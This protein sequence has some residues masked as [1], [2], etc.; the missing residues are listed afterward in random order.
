M[1][2]NFTPDEQELI[3]ENVFVAVDQEIYGTE[4][5][6]SNE[7]HLD[8]IL[9]EAVNHRADLIIIDTMAAAFT[10]ANENDNSEAEKVVIKPLKHI[11]RQTGAAILLVHHIGKQGETGDRSKLYAGRGASAFAAAARLVLNMEALKDGAGRRVD[12]HIVLSCAKVKGKPFDDTVFEL[13]FG[14][15]WFNPADIVLP[16]ETSRQEQIWAVITKPMKRKDIVA[17]LANQGLDV[18]DSTVSRALKLGIQTGK[19]KQ[20]A[21]QG[22]YIPLRLDEIGAEGEVVEEESFTISE[23]DINDDAD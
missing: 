19:I 17:A 16:D 20:G 3:N 13:D 23:E 12:G 22:T 11:A 9:D 2:Q 1:A 5:N 10:F 14:R 4:M 7:E 21:T 18:S 6:L 8:L 15:R